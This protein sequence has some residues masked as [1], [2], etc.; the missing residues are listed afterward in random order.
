[1]HHHSHKT[2]LTS[3]TLVHTTWHAQSTAASTF[4]GLLRAQMRCPPELFPR[5]AVYYTQLRAL[6]RRVRRTLQ[7]QWRLPLAGIALML[8]LEQQP[9]HAAT[10]PVSA[11]CTLVHAITAANTDMATNGC[12]AG[13]GADTIVLP[14]GSTQALTSVNNSTYGETGLPVISSVITIEGQ[15]S[16]IRRDV[17]GAPEFRI[18]AVNSTGDLTLNETTVSGGRA[19]RY[20]GGGVYN[21]GGILTVTNSIISGNYAADRSGGGVSNREG[22]LTV[23]NSTISGN[24]AYG[25][26]A[27]VFNRGGALTVTTST[28]ASN[29][30]TKG[31]G[32]GVAGYGTLTITNSTIT[33]NGSGEGTGGGVSF[34]GGFYGGGTLTVT[35]ST[36]AGN[37]AQYGGGGMYNSD[38]V[39]VTNS[40]IADN[41]VDYRGG[42]G[43][44]LNRGGTLTITNAT[45]AGNSTSSNF[46]PYSITSGGGVF[47][48]GGTVTIT[49]STIVG[50]DAQSL[51][52]GVVNDFGGTLMLVHTLVAGNTAP[53]G[54]EVGNATGTIL[55]NNHNLF[56]VNGN[57]GVEGF[58][59]GATDVVPG[60]GVQLADIINPT[61]AN[62]GGPTQTHAL[63]PGSP[64]IDAGGA[65]CSDG[66]G[67]PLL[68]DQRGKPRAVD[69]N[70]DGTPAC[71]IGA[72][73]FFPIVNNLVVLKSAP[74]TD[75]DP[76]P[77]MD[78]PAGT[79]TITATFTN[80]SKTPLRFPFFGVS[81][82]TGE[83]LVLNADGGPDGVGATVTPEV[84]GYVLAPGA[85]VTAEFV[86]GLQ[87]QKPFTFLVNLFG[88]PLRKPKHL[89]AQKRAR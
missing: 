22:T 34:R 25:N 60:A 11:G 75:F 72:F 50:N 68:T 33:G 64:A 74:A 17:D 45:I 52:G 65:V 8:A 48:S 66:S 88:E 54:L 19:P 43:G 85:S 62:N 49:N 16:T 10:I 86:L 57:A 4:P 89:G 42:G 63:V 32:G 15:G 79:F 5:A 82:L 9:L 67:S 59:P 3:K 55:G 7:R 35:N 37:V 36:I 12:P 21:H 71:D 87:E 23:T 69:G 18:L 56:G 28:I 20:E 76:T 26:G 77:V 29:F 78:A 38:T 70:G 13:S 39:T 47:N 1:M 73:E 30:T 83:N 40:T 61:L 53:I 58:S 51:G 41:F 27:G 31:G 24:R 6:P 44:V 80:T 84:A 14:A 2:V 81:Q 46:P